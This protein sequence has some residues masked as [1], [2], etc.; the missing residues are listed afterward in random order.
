MLLMPCARCC[1]DALMR[2][3][4]FALLRRGGAI[5]PRD[6]WGL[7]LLLSR[8]EPHLA[9][10]WILPWPS[11]M[12]S[13]CMM[14]VFAIHRS[15]NPTMRAHLLQYHRLSPYWTMLLFPVLASM[16]DVLWHLEHLASSR[17]DIS[18][19]VYDEAEDVLLDEEESS[20]VT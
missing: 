12:G 2:R 4:V 9:R 14:T 11:L 10:A 3:C 6:I 1:V 7:S 20:L 15:I 16:L 17:G 5:A 13:M 19:D 8:D 18:P